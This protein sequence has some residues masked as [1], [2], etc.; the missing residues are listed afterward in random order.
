M[1]THMQTS[2][3]LASLYAGVGHSQGHQDEGTEN[4]SSSPESTFHMNREANLAPWYLKKSLGSELPSPRA[5]ETHSNV[6]L[7]P[8]ILLHHFECCPTIVAT[9]SEKCTVFIAKVLGSMESVSASRH[10]GLP[11]SSA[12][13]VTGPYQ[14]VFRFALHLFRFWKL[15]RPI[16]IACLQTLSDPAA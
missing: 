10:P 16:R 11:P 14:T 3:T 15:E 7:E 8:K 5:E 6:M 12:R 13:E 4:K 9:A 1:V 2:V